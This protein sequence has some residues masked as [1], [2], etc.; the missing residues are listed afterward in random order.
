[1]PHP[2]YISMA[3]I[4]LNV[5]IESGWWGHR[6]RHVWRRGMTCSHNG[7][8]GLKWLQ[9]S[10]QVTGG[11][12]GAR[13]LQ[14]IMPLMCT[15]DCRSDPCGFQGSDLTVSLL[16]LPS[17]PHVQYR[18]TL[19]D[20]AGPVSRHEAWADLTGTSQWPMITSQQ[21]DAT[22]WKVALSALI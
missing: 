20:A 19:A 5:Y 9:L 7:N 17:V 2:A 22:V 11:G 1:M 4:H 15:V 16:S 14:W 13:P 3:T 21:A 12:Q 8:V 18:D 6:R 10:H